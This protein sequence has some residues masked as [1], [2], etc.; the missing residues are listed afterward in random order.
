MTAF[1]LVDITLDDQNFALTTGASSSRHC[2]FSQ[3]HIKTCL[4][5]LAEH[6]VFAKLL[7]QQP[8]IL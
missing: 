3:N 6:S 2:K 4:C 8:G 1:L 5:H 7:T